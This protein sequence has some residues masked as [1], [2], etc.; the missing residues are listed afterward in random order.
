MTYATGASTIVT[1]NISYD[2][3]F[4]PLFPAG[5]RA[6]GSAN[7]SVDSSGDLNTSG[8]ISA[9]SDI[10][11]GGD[12]SAAGNLSGASLTIGGIPATAT[13]TPNAIVKANGSGKLDGWLSHAVQNIVSYGGPGT[14]VVT[15]GSTVATVISNTATAASST[16]HILITGT[17][18]VD[19]SPGT[20]CNVWATVNGSQSVVSQINY[21]TE[22][23]QILN[24]ALSGYLTFSGGSYTIAVKL[25]RSGGASACTVHST[26][27]FVIGQ[28]YSN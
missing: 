19:V 17:V 3:G 8:Y 9:Y 7:L 25:Q 27:V 6:G 26:Q 2:A 18:S 20:T 13:P 5:L 1:S 16:G 22:A 28:E 15:S 11:S 14:D 4:G 23:G 10:S 24:V 12:V 21:L